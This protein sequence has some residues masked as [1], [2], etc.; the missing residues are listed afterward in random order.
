MSVFI[1]WSGADR[2]VKNVIAS[3]L[4]EE[5]IPYWDSDEHCKSDFSQECIENIHRSSVFVVIVSEASMAQGSYVFNEV[6]E[7]RRM[8]SEGRLNILVY[9]LTD[10][11]YTDR[12]SMQLNHISDANC[13]SRKQGLGKTGGIESLLKRIKL[14]LSRRAEGNPE[15]PY[16]VLLPQVVGIPVS[17]GGYFVQDSRND[18]LEELTGAFSTSNVVI[19][20]KLFGFGK[21]SVIRRYIATAG[22]P[23]VVEVQGMNDPLRR[24][25]LDRLHFSNVNDQVFERTD[26]EEI[27]R[28]KFELLKKLDER[29][30]IIVSDVSLEDEAD[31]YVCARLG[32][33]RCRMVLITQNSAEDY[34]DYFPVINV[35]RME[36]PYL[37]ELFFHY[38]DRGGDVDR[39]P[40]LPALNRF[41]E[42][43]G[44]HTKTVEVAA[45]VLSREMRARPEELIN[46]LTMGSDHNRTLDDRIVERLSE[47]I[48]ME[49]F[50]E[51]VKETLILIALLAD[52]IIEEKELLGMMRLCGLSHASALT[53]LENHRW[54]TCDARNQT[55]YIEPIIAQICAARLL[56]GYR[57]PAELFSDLSTRQWTGIVSADSASVMHFLTKIERF[58]RLLHMDAVADVFRAIR[59][60]SASS[61]SD[62]G[63]LEAVSDRFEE[64][65]RTMREEIGELPTEKES[66][67]MNVA[68]WV[69]LS[70]LPIL[71]TRLTY[72]TTYAFGASHRFS[73]KSYSEL[74]DDML[75]DVIDDPVA[76]DAL[77][78]MAQTGETDGAGSEV[79]SLFQSILQSFVSGDS[80]TVSRCIFSLIDYVEGD[81]EILS[82]TETA[83]Q[84]LMIVRLLYQA[85][86]NM[87]AYQ[88]AI[89]IFERLITLPWKSRY[90]HRVLMLYTSLL[91]C[92]GNSAED[93]VAAM[94]A[95]DELM[96]EIAEDPTLSRETRENT[97]REHTLLYA[98]VLA[99]GGEVDEAIARMEMLPALGENDLLAERLN[100]IDAI[101]TQLLCQSRSEDALHFIAESSDFLSECLEN[102]QLSAEQRE[103]AEAFLAMSELYASG[104]QSAFSAGGIV[105]DKSYYQRYSM[106]KKNGLLT[107]MPYNRIAKEVARFDFSTATE[108]ELLSHS[109][110]LRARAAAGEDRKRLAAEAFAL[111]SEAGFRTLGYRH[112]FV[113]YVGAA[114][115]LDGKVAEILNGEGK[116]YT[117][118]LVAYVN[119]LYYG[120]VL[121]LDDSKYLTERNYK[122][123]RGLYALLGRRV[124]YLS[125]KEFKLHGSE[126]QD[127]DIVYSDFSSFVFHVLQ[128]ELGSAR[129]RI[130]LSR[131]CA[132]F[133]EAD[134]IL[135]ESAS[136][137]FHLT[138]PA[139]RDEGYLSRCRTAFRLAEKIRGDERY[140]SVDGW[141]IELRQEV[142]S[143]LEQ[144]FSLRREELSAV[145]NMAEAERLLRLALT[146]LG[147]R[148]GEDYYLRDGGIFE[149]DQRS[150]GERRIDGERGYFLALIH[151]L[152]TE[153]YEKTLSV[154]QDL[155]NVTYVHTLLKR[156]A[157][158]AGTSATA[159]SFKKEFKSLYGLDVVAIPT[160]QPI[161]RTD[162]SVTL[163]LTGDA[164]E[165]AIVDMVEEKHAR[166][167]PILM[168]VTGLRESAR[169]SS[170]LSERGIAHQVL[171]A[172][173]SEKSPDLLATAGMPGSVLIATKLA[174]RGVDIK[175]GGDAERMTL[176][177]LVERGVDL[178]RI[179]EILYR[180]PSQEMRES[181]L[182]RIYSATL[183]QKRALVAAN[184][185]RVIEAGGLCVIGTEPHSDMRIEQ[186][187]RGRAGRQGEIGESYIYESMEDELFRAVFA[188][189]QW[190]MLRNLYSDSDLEIVDSRL[191]R[192][193]IEK[194][195]EQVHHRL[196]RGMRN[197]A[198]IA[199]R[200]EESR[201]DFFT[202]IEAAEEDRFTETELLADAWVEDSANADAILSLLNGEPCPIAC[203][204]PTLCE[205]CPEILEQEFGTA[206]EYLS[207]AADCYFATVEPDQR[208]LAAL[209]RYKWE[210]HASAMQE[211]ENTVDV[212]T[213]KN[214]DASIAQMYREDYRKKL[215]EA[216]DLLIYNTLK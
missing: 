147:M 169:Y 116:T 164:K 145:E 60:E 135:I 59:T 128:G 76:L 166:Q 79:A 171:N 205:R 123:M 90:L 215:T 102:E 108:A 69:K 10:A 13:V 4:A 180:L 152:P 183:E 64:W 55:V 212:R 156:F 126:L 87:S 75:G 81:P 36:S 187:I 24:F 131:C 6:I 138:R 93:A 188:N 31:R 42:D 199:R 77:E 119:S 25:F 51:E 80:S 112:H 29:H 213:L 89:S 136:S 33:L 43:V 86:V 198:Q 202:M 17:A 99:Q 195:K 118:A 38:Y 92:A 179:D 155:M 46:Y 201:R 148:C 39:A 9:K 97:G 194:Y 165:R 82:V 16:D 48:V 19:L 72:S 84:M 54:I 98:F 170:L 197:A 154:R 173:N 106:E 53:E 184:K 45:S 95:A 32:E 109:E 78:R 20:S 177:E 71:K 134:S 23:S 56:D 3:K 172:M 137:P 214:S 100:A 130:D 113:Q 103:K 189:R 94:M 12:F 163:F 22:V 88:T 34:R 203:A 178:A 107:M 21:K 196:F 105:T 168:I 216:F 142:Y 15:K 146:C 149:E 26:E 61:H 200:I 73:T 151:G 18:V 30:V 67:A 57:I 181:E 121:V 63:R 52:P 101:V 175:L 5:N 133:D 204:L 74:I 124:R 49:D 211:L 129:H 157:A 193:A 206:E 70:L 11:P 174:N 122:W 209:L 104:S 65:Y 41:F 14:L 35:G 50:S 120:T 115:M 208:C 158:V 162:E 8:E 140:Y 110:R 132:I 144:A 28:A 186:Q 96:E 125:P 161:Q 185:R 210:M 83:D 167:Q 7:A 91:S 37:Q 160:V 207:F 150:G 85:C 143:L 190:E 27:L 176:F 191:L 141:R 111:V 58:F 127:A 62:V 1:S 44:G 2:D 47:L 66:F 192:G 114:A 153:R 117:L 40:L 159:S 68:L 182:Y 139:K